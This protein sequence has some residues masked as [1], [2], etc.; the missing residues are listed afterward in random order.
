M[1]TRNDP[2]RSSC[3]L[4]CSL[5]ILGDKWTML[6]IRDMV[7]ARK[8]HFREFLESPE[9]IASNILTDR[10]KRLEESGIVSRRSDPDNARQVIY[11]LTEKGKDL[12]PVLLELAR[13]GAK[14]VARSAPPKNIARMLKQD[15]DGLI[16]YLRS[17]LK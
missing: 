9:G 7:L 13:W 3:P 1:T 12:I 14:H 5:D 2:Q 15:R 17:S 10:L 8:R 11:E 6:V 16:K 4:A